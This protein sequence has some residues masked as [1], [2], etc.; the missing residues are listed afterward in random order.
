M[1]HLELCLE[2]ARL[3]ALTLDCITDKGSRAFHQKSLQLF[4]KEVSDFG[5]QRNCIQI[6]EIKRKKT[7][8]FSLC[9]DDFSEMKKIF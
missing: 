1:C 2:K 4:G 9:F 5:L 3:R 8:S 7:H 6:S